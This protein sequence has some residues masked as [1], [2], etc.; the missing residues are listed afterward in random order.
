MLENKEVIP[1]LLSGGIPFSVEVDDMGFV[2]PGSV[3]IHAGDE[4]VLFT[5]SFDYYADVT[6]V[7]Y[8][9]GLEGITNETRRLVSDNLVGLGLGLSALDRSYCGVAHAI[10]TLVTNYNSSARRD[11]SSSVD[12]PVGSFEW[13]GGAWTASAS[14]SDIDVPELT[15]SGSDSSVS[16]AESTRFDDYICYANPAS[17]AFSVGSF[18]T[19]S[20]SDAVYWDVEDLERILGQYLEQMAALG[21]ET[22]D[23]YFGERDPL[24]F[25]GS[26]MVRLMGWIGD[27]NDYRFGEEFDVFV[28]DPRGRLTA[29][30]VS[31]CV[32]ATAS[33]SYGF[34][35]TYSAGGT[36]A[37]REGLMPYP[38]DYSRVKDA[39]LWTVF[40]RGAV[41][42]TSRNNQWVERSGQGMSPVRY[43]S[44]SSYSQA[45]DYASRSG[46]FSSLASA[47]GLAD[48]EYAY[49]RVGCADKFASMS[50]GAPFDN[51][52]VML[53]LVSSGIDES[54]TLRNVVFGSGARFFLE[55]RSNLGYVEPYEGRVWEIFADIDETGRIVYARTSGGQPLPIHAYSL[56]IALKDSDTHVK[57]GHEPAEHDFNGG[58]VAG[59]MTSLSRVNW[60][61]KA[62]KRERNNQ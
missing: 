10:P 6:N 14:G 48:A 16:P 27:L 45:F 15:E 32:S 22:A 9:A 11:Y 41:F 7:T 34:G 25:D 44:S 43:T 29:T 49:L 17:L 53:D 37:R 54:G 12:V 60:D 30:N 3:D 21:V 31:V 18:V 47:W 23:I 24:Y 8:H 59:R 35:H 20:V 62:L 13:D 42:G 39:T 33:T 26:G 1:G 5:M 52:L 36:L 4:D 56:S 46:D 61:W 51:P 40:S 55:L 50:G 2:I 58:A 38:G 57:D 19:N 28:E